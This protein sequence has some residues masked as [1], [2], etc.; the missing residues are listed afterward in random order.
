MKIIIDS[1]AGIKAGGVYV[2]GWGERVLEITIGK[3]KILT[4]SYAI[5][6]TDVNYLADLAKLLPHGNFNA[7]V[8][9]IKKK[10]TL[11]KLS[12]I[13][14]DTT[15]MLAQKEVSW[16]NAQITA[17]KS[18]SNAVMFFFTPI[19]EGKDLLTRSIIDSLVDL[20]I[21]SDLKIVSVP[22]CKIYQGPQ[23]LSMFRQIKKRISAKGKNAFFQISMDYDTKRLKSKVG[24]VLKVADGIVGIYADHV[25]YNFNYFYIMG[26]YKYKIVRVLSNV[27]RVYPLRG[28]NGIIPQMSMFFDIVS[29]EK[30][31][32][33]PSKKK[34][35]EKPDHELS[36]AKMYVRG[37]NRYYTFGKYE[38][39]F[40]QQLNCGCTICSGNTLNDLRVDYDGVLRKAMRIHETENIISFF[41]SIRNDIGIG[42]F[43]NYVKSNPSFKIIANTVTMSKKQR[44]IPKGP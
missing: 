19:L 20:Q 43:K 18:S 34:K 23:T 16:I 24:K 10:Y 26:L 32:F 13:V 35:E 25:K 31:E 8:A 11:E 6:Q 28:E 1:L 40:G 27:P 7:E 4:P 12:E 15:G 42:T 33:H 38:S 17:L 2:P 36:H 3:D 22:D 5:S 39:A 21:Q 37:Y 30:G 41:E 14:K 44:I 9:E 29:I